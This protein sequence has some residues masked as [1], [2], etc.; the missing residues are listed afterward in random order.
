MKTDTLVDACRDF[1]RDEESGDGSLDS[2]VSSM[3]KS[4]N[5]EKRNRFCGCIRL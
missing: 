2:L 5:D 3:L 1:I 4:K